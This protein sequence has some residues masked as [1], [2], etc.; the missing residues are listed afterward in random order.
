M[1]ATRF[2]FLAISIFYNP[3]PRALLHVMSDPIRLQKCHHPSPA[4]RTGLGLGRFVFRHHF[5]FS[6]R[7][8]LV[9]DLAQQ[10]GVAV[11][12]DHVLNLRAM[13]E[14]GEKSRLIYFSAGREEIV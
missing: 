6:R 2:H 9:N 12:G 7:D 1:P 5:R 14:L 3:F 8:G 4:F 11:V 13:L 10:F